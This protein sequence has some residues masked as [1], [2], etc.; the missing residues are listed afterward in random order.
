MKLTLYSSCSLRHILSV[1]CTWMI[2][3]GS[4]T[5]ILYLAVL[6]VAV[7]GQWEVGT[8]QQSIFGVSSSSLASIW[9]N[10]C[11]FKEI[12]QELRSPLLLPGTVKCPLYWSRE[13]SGCFSAQR[14]TSTSAL[15]RFS[16]A[17]V[18]G[19]QHFIPTGR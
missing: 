18:L 11:S 10:Q 1:S 3:V 6:R 15:G 5:K 13:V 7:R 4:L 8:L 9:G 14:G 2:R 16:Y 12:L 19:M 17:K